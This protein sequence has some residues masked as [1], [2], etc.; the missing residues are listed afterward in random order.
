[1]RSSLTAKK[2]PAEI[3]AV[4]T[5]NAIKKFIM[6]MAP[7]VF[8]MEKS[9]RATPFRILI[10][11][12]L[13]SRTQDPVTEKAA[14]R[15]FE[16]AATPEIMVRLSLAQVSRLIYPVGFYRTKA[17]N[18]LA[19]CR[20]LQQDAKFP[21]TLEELL[22]LPGIGRKSAN[23][24]LALAFSHPAIAVDTHVFRIARRL[25]WAGGRTAAAVE[26]ELMER[27]PRRFWTQVNQTLVGFGQTI[28]RPVNPKC[29]E[30]LL[31]KTCPSSE[32]TKL[33]NA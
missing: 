20:T 23:L 2:F 33:R 12:L 3:H 27:F 22:A 1:M 21:S 4:R 10:S 18:I 9:I 5:L 30:C 19:I 32:V 31:K 28:C 29:T 16:A 25:H 13:S 17:R 24:V 8:A 26:R 15:L 7:P 6:P 14:A 11:V